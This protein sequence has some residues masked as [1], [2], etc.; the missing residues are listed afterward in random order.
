MFVNMFAVKFHP[1]VLIKYVDKV[2]NMA[3]I[4]VMQG[5]IALSCLDP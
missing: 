5:C 4:V 2:I 1:N 3:T